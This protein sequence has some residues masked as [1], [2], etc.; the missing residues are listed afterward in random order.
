MYSRLFK[1]I[2]IGYFSSFISQKVHCQCVEKMFIFF[3]LMSYLTTL[4]KVFIMSKH[5]AA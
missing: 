3:I 1:H 4:L 2:E 5:F